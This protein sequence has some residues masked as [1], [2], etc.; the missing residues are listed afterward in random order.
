[1]KKIVKYEADD[2]RFFDTH[3][4]CEVY[5]CGCAIVDKLR[6]KLA[7]DKLTI[8]DVMS[9]LA[10]NATLV[11]RFAVLQMDLEKYTQTAPAEEELDGEGRE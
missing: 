4:E 1:M 6:A 8:S 9:I 7:H 10:A 11:K 3:Q 2:G 5:E